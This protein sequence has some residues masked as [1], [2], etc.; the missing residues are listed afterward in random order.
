MFYKV[1]QKAGPNGI[2][3]SYEDG[4]S[5]D[6]KC[7]LLE[8]PINCEGSWSQWSECDQNCY[9]E[10]D[11]CGVCGGLGASGDANYDLSIDILDVVL[12]IEY[13]LELNVYDVNACTTDISLDEIVNI[14]DL[15]LLLE[16]I[17]NQ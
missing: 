8:C 4:D 1:L 9:D 13:I 12:I 17:L 14:T 15:V 11:N 3:C 5:I 16:I 6:Q 10:I 2:P 7:N